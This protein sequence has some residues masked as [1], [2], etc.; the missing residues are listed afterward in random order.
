[1]Q[2]RKREMG[3]NSETKYRSIRESNLKE[4]WKCKENQESYGLKGEGMKERL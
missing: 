2:E 3:H 4:R 1:M